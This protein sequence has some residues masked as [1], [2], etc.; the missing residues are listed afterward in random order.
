MTHD[1]LIDICIRYVYTVGMNSI[2]YTIRNIP[3]QVDQTLRKRAKKAGKS[4]NQTVVDELSKATGAR[5]EG[6]RVYH[7]LDWFFGSGGIGPEEQKAFDAQRVID[8]EAWQK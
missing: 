4:F 3:P 5:V 8:E 7:D 6:P 1:F 2:Q